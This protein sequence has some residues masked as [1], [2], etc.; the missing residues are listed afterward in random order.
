MT[1]SLKSDA[2]FSL[3]LSG[4]GALGAFQV[5]AIKAFC[6][7]GIS[8]KAISGASIGALNASIVSTSPTLEVAHNRLESLW[9]S[10]AESEPNVFSIFF[11]TGLLNQENIERI[12][13]NFSQ[14]NDFSKGIPLYVSV[15][16]KSNS[17]MRGIEYFL[18][19]FNIK[20]TEESVFFHV[21]S[22]EKADQANAILASASVPIAFDHVA[23]NG[24]DYTDGG[25]GGYSKRQ[26]NTHI[27]PLLKYDYKIIVV[28]LESGS[29]WDRN[30]FDPGRIIEI[31][32][33][34]PLDTSMNP[35]DIFNF[36][37]ERIHKCIEQGYKDTAKI[38]GRYL[39]LLKD[40]RSVHDSAVKMHEAGKEHRKSAEKMEEAMDR[41]RNFKDE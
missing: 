12:I 28:H 17:I 23:I 4:G 18:A 27:T 26:G 7:Q 41:M 19:S 13:K 24:K 6:E 16:P 10:L 25:Q 38:L 40:A 8:I 37:K 20:D 31:R 33:L 35:A 15:Y 39:N 2:D 9:S 32:P 11:R 21:Q 30:D 3:V 1:V 34:S 5:G 22:L 36:S 29:P 14:D